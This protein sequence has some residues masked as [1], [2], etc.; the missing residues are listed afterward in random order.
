M[1]KPPETRQINR[2]AFV[3]LDNTG[4]INKICATNPSWQATFKPIDHAEL[5]G[6]LSEFRSK[7]V[8]R[9]QSSAIKE[10]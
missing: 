10:E 5:S 3:D 8:A 7:T 6:R 1:D 9:Y 4:P 2:A